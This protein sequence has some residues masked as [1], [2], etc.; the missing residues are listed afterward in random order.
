MH[1]F[2][3]STWCSIERLLHRLTPRLWIRLVA[4]EDGVEL[5]GETESVSVVRELGPMIFMSDFF[6]FF[7]SPQ[8]SLR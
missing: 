3:F 2:S 6:F 7:V 8:F 5:S 1:L 4:E